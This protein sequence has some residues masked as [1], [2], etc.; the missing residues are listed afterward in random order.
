[1]EIYLSQLS[2]EVEG[3]YFDVSIKK[4]LQLQIWLYVY[5]NVQNENQGTEYKI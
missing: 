5:Q 2:I 3:T 1:M 4:L